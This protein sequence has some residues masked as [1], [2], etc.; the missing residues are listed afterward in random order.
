MC[1]AM[2]FGHLAQN[3]SLSQS[4]V[5]RT[6]PRIRYTLQWMEWGR[7]YTRTCSYVLI[8]TYLP[9]IPAPDPP[10]STPP[11]QTW[12]IWCEHTPENTEGEDVLLP[13]L[14]CKIGSWNNNATFL[15]SELS[16]VA[17][18]LLSKWTFC[19]E[20][21]WQISVRE[22]RNVIRTTYWYVCIIAF[23]NITGK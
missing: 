23:M 12:P 10:P 7:W 1:A 15:Y 4:R 19:V 22:H 11:K 6:N 17:S 13:L 3:A 16:T 18:S 21:L 2:K 5:F 8:W 14:A 20:N 9:L